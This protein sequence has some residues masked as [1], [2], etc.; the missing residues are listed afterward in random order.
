MGYGT[1]F[2]KDSSSYIL[3]HLLPCDNQYR[4]AISRPIEDGSMIGELYVG[5]N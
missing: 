4:V 1:I 2:S 5:Y 3:K